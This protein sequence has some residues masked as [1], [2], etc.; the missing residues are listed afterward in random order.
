MTLRAHSVSTKHVTMD[1]SVL[2]CGHCSDRQT[3]DLPQSV[4]SVV[5][6]IRTFVRVHRRC[7]NAF[8]PDQNPGPRDANYPTDEPRGTPIAERLARAVLAAQRTPCDWDDL[9]DTV[10]EDLIAR[11]D[12]TITG[13]TLQGFH[14]MP[15]AVIARDDIDPDDGSRTR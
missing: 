15:L 5:A 6:L 4:D 11:A 3:I 1:G 13:L 10:Q 14:I 9:A 12:R 8:R 2:Y 7:K